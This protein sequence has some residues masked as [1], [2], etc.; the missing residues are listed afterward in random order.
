MTAPVFTGFGYYSGKAT[1]PTTTRSTNATTKAVGIFYWRREQWVDYAGP[2][3]YGGL[4]MTHPINRSGG[5][6]SQHAIGLAYILDFAGRANDTLLWNGQYGNNIIAPFLITHDDS[7]VSLITTRQAY[8]TAGSVNTFTVD[9]NGNDCVAVIFGSAYQPSANDLFS[10]W[11]A[12]NG[13]TVTEHVDNQRPQLDN[14]DLTMVASVPILAADGETVISYTP[15]AWPGNRY[16][17]ALALFGVEAP[18]GRKKR[19]PLFVF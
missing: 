1:D 6:S 16:N 4:N 7:P 15:A 12:S 5:S 11:S 2:T 10:S 3:K 18:A 17:T 19:A 9:P 14:Q 13:A 8:P